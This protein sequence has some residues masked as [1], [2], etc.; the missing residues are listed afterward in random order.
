MLMATSNTSGSN[1]MAARVRYSPNE[2]PMTP[3]RP[4]SIQ[5]MDSR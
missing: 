1:V 3:I 2:L 4:G 5:S